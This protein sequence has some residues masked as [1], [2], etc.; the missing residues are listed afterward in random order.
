LQSHKNV[1]YVVTIV[2]YIILE[3]CGGLLGART[4][5]CRERLSFHH[6]HIFY[7]YYLPSLSLPPLQPGHTQ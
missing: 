4:C 3:M 6:L 1:W 5:V 7:K 2:W